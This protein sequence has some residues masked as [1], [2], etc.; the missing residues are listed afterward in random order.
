MG[1][2]DDDF[3][4]E[5]IQNALAQTVWDFVNHLPFELDVL[6]GQGVVTVDELAEYWKEELEKLV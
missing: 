6:I 2:T 1:K 3:K 4:R 5:I